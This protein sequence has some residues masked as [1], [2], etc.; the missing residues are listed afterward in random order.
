MGGKKG[1]GLPTELNDQ[2]RTFAHAVA[3]G[4]NLT[5]AAEAAG[6]KYPNRVGSRHYRNPKVRAEVER[7]RKLIER[8][9]DPKTV[10]DAVELQAFLTRLV[11][12]YADEKAEVDDVPLETRRRAAMDLAKLQGLIVDRSELTG[13][14][15]EA[16]KIEGLGGLSRE[17]LE[18]RAQELLAKRKQSA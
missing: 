9:R 18:K 3:S 2:Q 7:L 8:R 17:E 4:K 12:G 15:G 6:Y 14:G 13:K 1:R 10:A 5:E 16:I 11:R